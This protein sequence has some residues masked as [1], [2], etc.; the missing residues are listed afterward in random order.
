VKKIK[1]L[2][3]NINQKE[4]TSK[5]PAMI[6]GEIMRKDADVIILTEFLKTDNYKEILYM[7]LKYC[8]YEVFL[9]PR[10]PKE[11]IR[12]VLIAVRLEIIKNQETD[13]IYLSDNEGNIKYGKYPNFLRIDLNIDSESFSIIGTRIRIWKSSGEEEQIRR[14]DQFISLLQSIPK[15]RNII[16]MGDF[17]I[18]DD[19]MYK[20]PG[21]KWHFDYDYNKGL[22]SKGL[23]Y[24][25]IV[26]NIYSPFK[27]KLKLDHLV[28]SDNLKVESSAYYYNESWPSSGLN[29]PDHSISFAEII[30]TQ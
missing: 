5:T 10:P 23:K 25:P 8:G 28:V 15:D 14:K 19:R 26:G 17:N 1:F 16:M 2:H 13:P 6:I 30:V 18:S 20:K 4:E 24:I 27:S 3:W 7:P 9:D 21:S 12:Q 11:K 29:N 22:M